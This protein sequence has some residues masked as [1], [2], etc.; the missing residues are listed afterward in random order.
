MALSD[1]WQQGRI[2]VCRSEFYKVKLKKGGFLMDK[3]KYVPD[4]TIL[5]MFLTGKS[6]LNRLRYFKRVMVLV[7]LINLLNLPLEFMGIDV[8]NPPLAICVYVVINFS[9]F[10]LIGYRLDVR[11]LHDSGKGKTLAAVSVIVNVGSIM[12]QY[13]LLAAILLSLYILFVPGSK[14]DNEYGPDPLGDNE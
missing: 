8:N 10:L 1:K 4:Q 6:R 3:Q 13:V 7:I 2:Y 14:G 9:L 5:E 12:S 11:R